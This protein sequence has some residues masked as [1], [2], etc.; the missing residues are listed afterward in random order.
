M[1]CPGARMGSMEPAKAPLQPAPMAFLCAQE[2]LKAEH[3][4][5]QLFQIER[6]MAAAREE[7]GK[8]KEELNKAA[9]ALHASE[10]AVEEKKQAA[11]GASKEC[12]LLERKYKKRKADLDKKACAPPIPSRCCTCM[13]LWPS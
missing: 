4:L 8:Q 1:A 6:D 5:W 9:K 10:K 3:Y 13:L 7:A 2:S 11:A 12:M